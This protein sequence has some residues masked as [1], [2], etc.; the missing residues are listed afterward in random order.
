MKKQA[1]ALLNEVD[2]LCKV[3]VGKKAEGEQ[4]GETCKRLERLDK[5]AKA[6]RRALDA[7][8]KAAGK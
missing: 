7:D 2:A 6:L 4:W 1:E 8:A 3:Y 5:L